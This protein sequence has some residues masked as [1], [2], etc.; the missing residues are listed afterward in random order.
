M[1]SFPSTP[2]ELVRAAPSRTAARGP[3]VLPPA[4]D[5]FTP[6]IKAVLADRLRQNVLL[7]SA[8]AAYALATL[9]L[10]IGTGRILALLLPSFVG[11]ACAVAGWVVGVL[12]VVIL[13]KSYLGVSHVPTVSPR[14]ALSRALHNSGYKSAATVYTA[15]ALATLPLHL[16]VY[17]A[18]SDIG[19]FGGS[20]CVYLLLA[21]VYMTESLSQETSLSPRWSLRVPCLHTGFTSGGI[22][23]PFRSAGS[24]CSPLDRIRASGSGTVFVAAFSY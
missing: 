14:A 10:A 6:R 23:P 4:A 22:P 1:S 21:G 20:R 24:I 3:P 8:G 7:P 17:Q 13:R 5:S 11:I 9:S 2:R 12:P 19:V 16:L 15:S 18:D